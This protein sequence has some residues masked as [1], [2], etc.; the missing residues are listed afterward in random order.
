MLSV[1]GNCNENLSGLGFFLS[2]HPNLGCRK[3]SKLVISLDEDNSEQP[4]YEPSYFLQPLYLL[5]KYHVLKV[6]SGSQVLSQSS[7]QKRFMWTS[8]IVIWRRKELRLVLL[9][10]RLPVSC[11]RSIFISQVNNSAVH[12]HL[13]FLQRCSFAHLIRRPLLLVRT[14]IAG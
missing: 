6:L 12:W 3:D 4:T 9:S 7:L 11:F 1:E 10:H 13:Y 5:G 8:T 14:E 2:D